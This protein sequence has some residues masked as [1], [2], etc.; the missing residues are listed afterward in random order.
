MKMKN[1]KITI[2]IP[3]EYAEKLN[4]KA[5]ELQVHKTELLRCVLADYLFEKPHCMEIKDVSGKVTV[6]SDKSE[7]I[8]VI[9]DDKPVEGVFGTL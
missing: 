8:G 7:K 5:A 2:S 4:K 1:V 9:S 6:I 3:Q